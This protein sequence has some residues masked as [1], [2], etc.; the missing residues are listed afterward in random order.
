MTEENKILWEPPK[1]GPWKSHAYSSD[2][3]DWTLC[4]CFHYKWGHGTEPPEE[5]K[6]KRCLKILARREG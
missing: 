5:S 4:G 6:C 1:K 3:D 2:K